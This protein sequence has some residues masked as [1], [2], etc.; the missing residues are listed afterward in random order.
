[1]DRIG[2]VFFGFVNIFF[3]ARMLSKSELGIWLL[4]TSVTSILEMLRN[5]F[6]RN[7]FITHL[8]SANDSEKSSIVTSSFLLHCGLAAF[9][10]LVLVAG[11]APL[12]LFWKAEGLA[13]LFYIYAINSI[14]FIPYF[15]LL[16][17]QHATLKF[18]DVFIGNAV[19][20]GL[21]SLFIIYH[22]FTKDP[23]TL[24]SLAIAQL[25]ATVMATAVR[26]IGEKRTLD[27][28]NKINW[29]LIKELFHFGKFT[30]GTNISSMLV[31]NTDSWMIGRMISTA[32][33]A[34]YNPAVRI[35]NLVEV[36]TLAI[37]SVF[38]PQVGKKMKESGTE[39]VRDIYVKS[40][41][42]ILA[43]T[44]PVV[45]PIYLFPEFVI[46]LIFGPDY[47]D[48]AVILQVTLFYT[49]LVPFNRQ[50][51]TVMDGTKRP[52]LNFYLL[53]LVA[54]LNLVFN[55]FFLGWFGL[56]GSAFATLLSYSV[57]FI[58]NQIILY[59]IF[60]INT[61]HVFI[62][63]IEWYKLGWSLF[64]RKVLKLA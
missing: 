58:L 30:L 48:A 63:I 23:P 45:V 7:P 19:R 31:K 52:K 38:F 16:Y 28:N 62:E 41:S 20:L 50:F 40:V 11:G 6:I 55:Y 33:V 39:G 15:H 10:S 64:R 32:G 3:L 29:T 46:T 43:L 47:I 14:I 59:N 54:T 34:M 21:L 53:V 8:V 2:Q 37:A 26:Y 56:V 44:L 61:L 35:S 13:Q 27:F 51:G 24:V 18:K 4:F 17:I 5:G 60:R 9:L 22:F 49:L 36:P 57:V 1:M 42:L 12:A 25:V